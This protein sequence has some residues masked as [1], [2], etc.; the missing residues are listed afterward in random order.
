MW[1]P[2]MHRSVGLPR[3]S[4]MRVAEGDPLEPSLKL[5]MLNT[6]QRIALRNVSSLDEGTGRDVFS[7]KEVENLILNDNEYQTRA[8]KAVLSPELGGFEES[9]AQK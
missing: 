9:E 3:A 6:E 8:V 2:K 5:R 7:R 1:L 4:S